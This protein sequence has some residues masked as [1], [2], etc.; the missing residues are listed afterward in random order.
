[1]NA[2]FWLVMVYGTSFQ[3]K[4]HVTWLENEYLFGTRRMVPR[5]PLQEVRE[6]ILP[7]KRQLSTYQTVLFRREARTTLL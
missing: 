6:L 5:L 4:K 1:M 3:M 2:L 7:L